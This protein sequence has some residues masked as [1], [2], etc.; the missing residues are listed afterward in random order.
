VPYA[1]CR[2]DISTRQRRRLRSRDKRI[3]RPFDAA[4]NFNASVPDGELR[5]HA[6]RGAG[7]TVLSQAFSFVVQVAATVVLARIL[8]PADFGLVTMVTTFSLLLANFGLNGFTEAVVQRE[9]LND[10]LVSNLFWINLGGGALLTIAFAEA[11]PWLA[12][13]YHNTQIVAVSRGISLTILLN[14][15]SVLHLSLLQRALRFT[16]ISKNEIAARGISVAVSI[17][18][19]S[20]GWGY[21]A[22]VAGAIAQALSTA[23]G[24]WILCRWIPRPPQRVAGTSSMIIY[25]VNV[26]G[27]FLF[28][29][30]KSNLDNLLVGWHFGAIA[31]GLYKRAFD[32][33]YLPASQVLDPITRAAVPALCRLTN[34]PERRERYLLHSFSILAFVGMGLSGLLTLTG[35]DLTHLVLGP[36]WDDTGRIFTFFA[37]GVGAMFLYA[38]WRWI[39]LS[40]GHGRRYA[41]WGVVALGVT[42]LLFFLMLP[43]GAEGLAIAWSMSYWILFLPAVWYAGRPIDFRITSVIQVV[44]RYVVASLLAGLGSNFILHQ[45]PSVLAPRNGIGTLI[46]LLTT[47]GLFGVLYLGIAV[48]LHGSAEPLS[49][50]TKLLPDL[51]PWARSKTRN[52]VLQDPIDV[53]SSSPKPLDQSVEVV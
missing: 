46:R 51:T 1:V 24:A 2:S 38:P 44:W 26:Y 47:S 7:V 25:A 36:K 13:F 16:S 20:L 27:F 22:L 42:A 12:R 31:L 45:M 10:Q 11:G 28:N 34:D 3:V 4:G 32:L 15:A 18:L 49:Q 14:C 5:G 19:G 23:I 35:K 43:W 17:V 37:P 6:I 48:L 40:L 53:G 50:I 21:K 33:F 41:L 29:Y 30:I 39:P 8:V 52:S 9:P